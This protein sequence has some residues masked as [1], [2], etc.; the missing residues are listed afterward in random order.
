MS[1]RVSKRSS[2]SPKKLSVYNKFVKAHIKKVSA[3]SPKQ[4]MKAVALLWRKK[5]GS[6]KSHKKSHKRSAKRSHKRS[7]R[8]SHKRSHRRSHKRSHTV[9]RRCSDARVKAC[10]RVGK[11]CQIGKSG[12][13]SCRLSLTKA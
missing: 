1:K 12:R 8:R 9:V 5:H 7:H 3:K 10:H 4:A 6:K 11:V 2:R 13:Q